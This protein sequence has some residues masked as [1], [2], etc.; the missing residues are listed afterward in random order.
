MHAR[1]AGQNALSLL[2]FLAASFA[3]SALGGLAT[4]SSITTWY[5]TLAKP[6]FNPPNWLFGPVWTTLY[7]MIAVAGWRVWRRV[8]FA[9][10][11]AFAAFGAQ[12]ALNLLW[13]VLFFGLQMLGPALAGLVL[14]WI[15]IAVTLLM[16]W[17]HDR[18]ASLLFAPYLAW[19]SFAGALN[20]AIWSLN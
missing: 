11:R 4:A 13:P 14:L 1:S 7:I 18:A 15:S 6:S 9:D 17:R 19:V 20:A 8:G 2:G 16:F 3:V 5:P 12:L 10:K